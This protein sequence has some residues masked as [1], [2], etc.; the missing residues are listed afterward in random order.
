MTLTVISEQFSSNDLSVQCT[1]NNSNSY[2]NILVSTA[3]S[4][5]P[6]HHQIIEHFEHERDA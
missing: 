3:C 1:L 4:E 6:Y 5:Y 2:S